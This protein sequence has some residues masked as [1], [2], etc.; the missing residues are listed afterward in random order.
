MATLSPAHTRPS[1]RYRAARPRNE[2]WSAWNSPIT[3]ICATVDRPNRSAKSRKIEFYRDG[4]KFSGRGLGTPGSWNRQGSTFDK[5]LDG[6]PDS[7][8][9]PHR[10]VRRHRYAIGPAA[11]QPARK[12]TETPTQGKL[13]NRKAN[14]KLF[15]VRSSP[16]AR[17]APP[18]GGYTVNEYESDIRGPPAYEKD[19]PRNSVLRGRLIECGPQP[20]HCIHVYPSFRERTVEA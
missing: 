7:F 4:V 10:G 17:L 11:W 3:G 6:N 20:P 13:D 8:F 12:Q 14:S 15:E 19:Q 5:A 9:D 2:T 16:F 18:N 1:T